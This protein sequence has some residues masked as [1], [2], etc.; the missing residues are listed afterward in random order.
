MRVKSNNNNKKAEIYERERGRK[1]ERKK[2]GVG[3]RGATEVS[4][5]VIFGKLLEC[6]NNVNLA[7]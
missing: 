6:K 1:R 5:S 7:L 2:G 4:T 3:G